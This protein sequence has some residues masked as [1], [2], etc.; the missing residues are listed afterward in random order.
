MKSLIDRMKFMS[1][2]HIAAIFLSV[3]MS[4]CAERSQMLFLDPSNAI[5]SASSVHQQQSF[6]LDILF[7]VESSNNNFSSKDVLN[8]HI[9]YF[10]ETLL[11]RKEV[12]DFHVGFT[13]A[14]KGRHLTD[15][16]SKNP[17]SSNQDSKNPDSR[18]QDADQIGGF[19]FFTHE[20]LDEMFS[21]GVFYV[22]TLQKILEM[23]DVNNQEFFDAALRVLTSNDAEE[24]EF[25]RDEAH[26]LLVFIGG[27][28]QSEDED[29][30][31]LTQKVL[32]LKKHQKDK[33][34]ALS[35]FPIFS[36]C[37]SLEDL[38]M[39]R[40][41]KFT[42]RFNGHIL[43]LC[44]PIFNKLGQVAQATYQRVASIPLTRIPLLETVALCY[45]SSMILQ[46]VFQ[47][48]SYLPQS[49]KI[50]LAWDVNLYLPEFLDPS[51]DPEVKKLDLQ[52]TRD[53]VFKSSCKSN[54]GSP[55]QLFDLTYMS[56]SP[57]NIAKGLLSLKEKPT[58]FLEK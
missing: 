3:F 53:S 15:Q 13:M 50:T 17:D 25:Y 19:E 29:V 52:T 28:D 45:G 51:S 58:S 55:P 31:S 56:T 43:Y 46:D 14:S 10:L 44:S 12:I 35:I 7:V 20:N 16:D 47:G 27:D 39:Q 9:G 33:V 1:S 18:N 37:F 23:E 40:L 11:S 4:A 30:E 49:N 57:S 21:S 41:E 38:D 54:V 8:E 5:I 22:E 42:Q 36:K 34:H 32:E 24:N 2:Y 48:W 6:A 26:L